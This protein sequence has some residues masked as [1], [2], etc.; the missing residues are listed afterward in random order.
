MLRQIGFS[1]RR[2]VGLTI[3]LAFLAATFAG[4]QMVEAGGSGG[5]DV[6]V[7]RV[8][9]NGVRFTGT[10]T[11]PAVLGRT[12]ISYVFRGHVGI[13]SPLVA[14]G[15]SAVYSAVG[16]TRLFTVTYPVGTFA[17]GDAVTYSALANDTSGYGGGQ[18]AYVQDCYVGRRLVPPVHIIARLGPM[19]T[20]WVLAYA[21]E[22]EKHVKPQ[23]KPTSDSGRVDEIYLKVKGVWVY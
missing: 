7:A 1:A 3:V 23:L 11:N 12:I 10:V 9:L 19:W 15:T 17:V 14:T 6:Q 2:F 13:P 16:Q 8:C 22:L 21:P 18:F 5:I 4:S 20:R